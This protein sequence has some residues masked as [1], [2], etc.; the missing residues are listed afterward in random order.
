MY[1]VLPALPATGNIAEFQE[2]HI[3]DIGAGEM[4]I[5]AV[6]QEENRRLVAFLNQC[7]SFALW[8]RSPSVLGSPCQVDLCNH[9]R[10]PP[11]FDHQRFEIIE[12]LFH[13]H[14]P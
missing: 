8:R 2:W 9:L 11:R 14:C 1:L 10:V 5:P 7:L 12:M 6:A 13:F 4:F 3:G